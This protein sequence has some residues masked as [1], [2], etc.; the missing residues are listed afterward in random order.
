MTE[1]TADH[2]D[3][4]QSGLRDH[5]RDPEGFHDQRQ[6]QQIERQRAAVND[7]KTRVFAY[8]VAFGL[9]DEQLISDISIGNAQDT[10]DDEQDHIMKI[11]AQQKIKRGKSQVTEDRI[12]AADQQVIYLV[13]IFSV[14][15]LDRDQKLILSFSI[16]RGLFK[17]CVWIAP[18]YSP[19]MPIKKS[20]TAEK[21]NRPMTSGAIPTVKLFQKIS[22]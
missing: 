4:S 1:V 18:I 2:G 14:G 15:V 9:E 13:M 10:A 3:Q 21:K 20:W 7:I 8:I 5:G 12:P 6:Q 22:L 16:T 11:A 19:M 17:T